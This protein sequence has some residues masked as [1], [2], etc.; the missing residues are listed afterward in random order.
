MLI[1]GHISKE[2]AF[3]ILTSSIISV[4]NAYSYSTA[5]SETSRLPPALSQHVAAQCS[6][7]R[8]QDPFQEA[9]TGSAPPSTAPGG[10]SV[11]CPALQ[12]LP[13]TTHLPL[14]HKHVSEFSR[15]GAGELSNLMRSWLTIG[16]IIKVPCVPSTHLHSTGGKLGLYW[17]THGI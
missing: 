3:W 12:P 4:L 5:P 8:S 2:A 7:L 11:V 16:L 17:K 6:A 1:P 9:I 13:T 15:R 14:L 10:A